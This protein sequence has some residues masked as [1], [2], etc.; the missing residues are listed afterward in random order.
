M[1]SSA[2]S[3]WR[4]TLLHEISLWNHAEGTVLTEKCGRL[5]ALDW[6]VRYVT[7]MRGFILLHPALSSSL[8]TTVT[9][10]F[11]GLVTVP[12]ALN[13]VASS[14]RI[15]KVIE[16]AYTCEVWNTVCNSI[17]MR[18]SARCLDGR[19]FLRVYWK[20]TVR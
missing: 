7:N 2:V 4:R 19:R 16:F 8:H 17:E 6:T 13:V 11:V 5:I 15:C 1:T 3:V 12:T 18:P 14:K 10:T 9:V 20:P